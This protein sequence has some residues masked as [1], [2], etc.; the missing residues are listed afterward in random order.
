MAKGR[1]N[2][3]M[4]EFESAVNHLIVKVEDTQ[5]QVQ[6]RIDQAVE[7]VQRPIDIARDLKDRGLEGARRVTEIVRSNPEPYLSWAAFAVGL[8]FCY[9]AIRNDRLYRGKPSWSQ[10]EP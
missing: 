3:S 1:V 8:Y 2:A 5:A 10:L 4:A 7:T 6:A 9:R